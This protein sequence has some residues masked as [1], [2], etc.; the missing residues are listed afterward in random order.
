MVKSSCADEIQNFQTFDST[1]DNIFK[2]DRFYGR[3]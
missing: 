1:L 2:V 3:K